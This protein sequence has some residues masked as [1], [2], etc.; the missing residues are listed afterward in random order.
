[1]CVC[2]QLCVNMTNERVRLYVS[3]VLFHQEQAECLQE[4]IAMET[5]RSPSNQPAVLDFLF[6]VICFAPAV[7]HY[8]LKNW[9]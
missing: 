8:P 9:D 2:S 6:Q 1:M 4:A 5:L 3:E 7:P